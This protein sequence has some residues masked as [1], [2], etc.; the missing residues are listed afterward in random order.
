MVHGHPFHITHKG[1]TFSLLPMGLVDNALDR[2]RLERSLTDGVS[3]TYFT[4]VRNTDCVELAAGA[5]G[6][7]LPISLNVEARL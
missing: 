1:K 2:R 3:T 7:G 4:S 6:D 5:R